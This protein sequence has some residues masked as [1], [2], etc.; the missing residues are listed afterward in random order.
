MNTYSRTRAGEP[1]PF[2]R[3]DGHGGSPAAGCVGAVLRCAFTASRRTNGRHPRQMRK[4]VFCGFS[5]DF[6]NT[7]GGRADVFF[8]CDLC[9]PSITYHPF[10]GSG[11]D[12]LPFDGTTSRVT[13]GV[14][15]TG[16]PSHNRVPDSRT[17]GVVNSVY[18]Q[19]P[20]LRW[21]GR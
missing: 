7:V 14:P 19:W 2:L 18:Q 13:E 11:E 5:D 4:R 16:N 1:I 15:R 21:L 20:G 3:G 6:R 12:R 9:R 8:L 10:L 17:A